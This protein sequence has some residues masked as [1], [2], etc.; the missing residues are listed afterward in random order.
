M[1][2]IMKNI[3]LMLLLM[4]SISEACYREYGGVGLRANQNATITGDWAFTGGFSVDSPTFF[5]D[6]ANNRVGIGTITPSGPLHVYSST[7]ASHWELIHENVQAGTGATARVSVRNASSGAAALNL[8]CQGT[9]FTNVGGFIK[10]G[11]TISASSSLSGGLSIMTRAAAPI[12][13]YTAGHTNERMRIHEDGYVGSTEG[14]ILGSITVDEDSSQWL[15]DATHGSATTTMY[16]GNNTI[17]VTAP[18]DERLKQ[19]IKPLD[20]GLN[21]ILN[22][23]P[24]TFNY[25]FADGDNAGINAQNVQEIYPYAVQ[26]R[27]DGYLQTDYKKLI[28]LLINAIKEQQKQINELNMTWLD[29]L[30]RWYNN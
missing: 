25:T 8:I 22:L 3:I 10:D 18:S 17:D 29:R 27:S 6:A 21:E 28:P 30:I 13:F 1:K 16:I 7:E 12:R 11:A 19:N 23:N 4:V 9:N 20:A 14:F 2:N 24:V 5:V 15:D 26:Q